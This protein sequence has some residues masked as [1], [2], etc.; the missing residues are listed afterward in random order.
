MPRPLC[1]PLLVL[2]GK[3]RISCTLSWESFSSLTMGQSGMISPSL[4]WKG[5]K[6]KQPWAAQILDYA[7]PACLLAY[8]L[9]SLFQVPRRG[10]QLHRPQE[11]CLLVTGND[12]PPPHSGFH[13][14]QA[15]PTC[16]LGYL[17]C[18]KPGTWHRDILRMPSG[19]SFW[20]VQFLE[21]QGLDQWRLTVSFLWSWL[22][23]ATAK[24]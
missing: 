2:R 11:P 24:N 6:I 22:P 1:F 14:C 5:T 3:D 19:I 17:R 15:S 8:I 16:F 23:H 9:R 10:K 12:S 7:N 13:F 20:T 21:L 4:C 18:L